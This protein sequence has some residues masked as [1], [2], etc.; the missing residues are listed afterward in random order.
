MKKKKKKQNN[1]KTVNKKNYS[2]WPLIILAVAVLFVAVIVTL[3]LNKNNADKKNFTQSTSTNSTQNAQVI[4][5]GESLTIPISE[6]SDTAKFYPVEIDGTQMEIIAVKDSEGNI[7]TA[8]NTCQICYDSG[9][10]YYKQVGN[11]LVCQNCGNQFTMDQI[12]IESG[13]CNPWPIFSE[14]KTVTD[15]SISIS[16]DFLSETKEIFANWKT[17][18]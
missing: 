15:E 5:Q 10:G 13:S 14:N 17:N 8:F 16:Y 11:K 3:T 7:R 12:E 6:L 18:Y 4:N 1:K 9:R 2:N